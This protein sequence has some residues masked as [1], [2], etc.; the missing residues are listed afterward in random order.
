MPRSLRILCL[1][2]AGGSLRYGEHA[3]QRDRRLTGGFGIDRD[4]VD[5]LALRQM[6]QRPK[7][8]GGMD[9]IHRRAGTDNRIEAEDVLVGKL[10]V[11]AVDQVDLGA[12]S[13]GRA[14]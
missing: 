4:L 13:P 12:N 14:G 9:A 1:T 11:E 10:R 5:D 2:E 6:L 3:V 7:N 8:V